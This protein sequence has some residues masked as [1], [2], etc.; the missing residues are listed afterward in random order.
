MIESGPARECEMVLAFL[1]AELDSPRWANTLLQAL[2]RTG[3][4]RSQLFEEANL[5]DPR[6]NAARRAILGDYRGFGAN[7][8]LFRGF[9]DDAVWRR[10]AIDPADHGRLIYANSPPWIELSDRTRLVTRLAEKL[11]SAAL[12]PD[13]ADHVR[14][15]QAELKAGKKLPELIAAEGSNGML[16]LIEGHCRATAYVGLSWKESIPAFLASSSLMHR[17]HWY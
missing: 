2:A 13:T 8:W 7:N 15:V 10:A 16:I 14:A 6:Q 4:S 1:K 3:F 12:P 9:P 17:W 5:D 11:I